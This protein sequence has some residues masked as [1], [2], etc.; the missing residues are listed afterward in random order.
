RENKFF[1]NLIYNIGGN[2]SLYGLYLSGA[3]YVQ[4][5][6]NTIVL[7]DAT[8]TSGTTYGIYST[9]TVGGI[10]IQNNIIYIARGGTGTK[11]CL[12]FSGAGAKNSNYNNLY[13]GSTSGTNN[14]GYIGSAQ[15]SLSAWQSA[16]GAGSP[17]DANSWDLDPMF[18]NA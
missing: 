16:T 12:Y 1:N 4:A 14:I 9:G 15:S 3:D 13:M 18:V 6:H 5:Y 8:A 2:G 11:Y 7:D 17:Y 10:D